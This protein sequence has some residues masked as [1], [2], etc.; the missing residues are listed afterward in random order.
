MRAPLLTIRL[1][2]PA[3]SNSDG[4]ERPASRHWHAPSGELERRQDQPEARRT[5]APVA[6]RAARS[7]R[8]SEPVRPPVQKS[9]RLGNTPHDS[10]STILE[11][12]KLGEPWIAMPTHLVHVQRIPPNDRRQKLLVATGPRCGMEHFD[13]RKAHRPHRP[14][15]P[16]SL[17]ISMSARPAKRRSACSA[18]ASVIG[19][20]AWAEDLRC[21]CSI[22]S[23]AA[24]TSV[25]RLTSSDGACDSSSV[26]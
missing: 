20:F 21:R 2:T 23:Q 3:Q 15:Q 12:P 9:H 6:R 8:Q 26:W 24:C 13:A 5:T 16:Q 19:P 18:D 14:H 10:R 25:P 4:P 1:P 7:A 17:G 22:A 11:L